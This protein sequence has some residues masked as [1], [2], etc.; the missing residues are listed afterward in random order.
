M[1][2]PWPMVALALLLLL[3]TARAERPVFALALGGGAA[4]G[5]AHL[6]V[7]DVLEQEGLIPDLVLGASM[8]SLMGGFYCSGMEPDL[9]ASHASE[10]GIWKLLDLQMGGLGFLEWKRVRRRLEPL[11]RVERLEDCRP[12][13]VCVA[14]DLLSGERVMLR[15][16]PLLDAMLAS[17]AVPGLYEPVEWE[18]R[19]LVDGGLVDEVP[20]LSARDLGADVIVAVDVSHPLLGKDLRGPVDVMRQGYFILQKQNV[21]HRSR[22]ADLVIRPDL[23]GLDFHAFDE[24]DKARAAGRAAARKAIP[25]LRRILLEKGWNAAP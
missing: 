14:T 4:L 5:Y 9:I 8:G 11:L 23:A 19:L 25:A 16:G 21:E 17:A 22:L 24:V 12:A 6:G 18:G 7:L 3:V 15:R 20:V 2:A 10:L 13:L 1:R